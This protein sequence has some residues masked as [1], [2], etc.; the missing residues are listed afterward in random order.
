MAQAAT[1]D[2]GSVGRAVVDVVCGAAVVGEMVVGETSVVGG[3][4]E[5]SDDES[6][7]EPSGAVVVDEASG[8]TAVSV[9]STAEALRES[10]TAYTSSWTRF[11]PKVSRDLV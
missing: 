8:S 1:G 9:G 4:S 2:G 3:E 7:P 11:R 10:V 6:P 5:S